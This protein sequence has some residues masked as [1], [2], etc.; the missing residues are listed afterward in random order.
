MY[1][2]AEWLDSQSELNSVTVSC[3]GRTSDIPAIVDIRGRGN[4]PLLVGDQVLAEITHSD[5][6]E[7]WETACALPV[8]ELAQMCKLAGER[9]INALDERIEL[10][11]LPEVVTDAAVLFL[12]GVKRHGIRSPEDIPACSVSYHAARGEEVMALSK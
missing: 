9:L 5:L 4:L 12:L 8:L 1:M 3:P 11:D 7:S 6:L 10:A 2:G